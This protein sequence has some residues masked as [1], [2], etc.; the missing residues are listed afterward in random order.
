MKR[1][2]LVYF[3]KIH[4]FELDMFHDMPV[5]KCFKDL[6]NVPFE[7]SPKGVLRWSDQLRSYFLQNYFNTFYV[8]VAVNQVI[9]FLLDL[10]L[11]RTSSREELKQFLNSN[12]RRV[13]KNRGKYFMKTPPKVRNASYCNDEISEEFGASELSG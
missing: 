3:G 1:P 11:E 7:M 10:P 13:F 5:E 12:W 9:K 8:N 2:P 6:F 4:N